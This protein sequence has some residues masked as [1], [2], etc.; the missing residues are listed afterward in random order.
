ML[1]ELQI[2]FNV[3]QVSQKRYFANDKRSSFL[4]ALPLARMDNT[5]SYNM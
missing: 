1:I 5:V 3:L 4:D 2:F